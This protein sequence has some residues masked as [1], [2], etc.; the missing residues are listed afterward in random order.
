MKKFLIAAAPLA[1]L[2]ACSGGGSD[3]LQAG[4]WTMTTTMTD[5]E[6]PGMPEEMVAQMRESMGDQANTDTEC[7]TEEEAANPLQGMFS[8]N[9]MG[10]NCDF[11]ESTFEGGVINISATCEAPGGQPG[12]ATMAIEGTYTATT[13]EAEMSVA[14]EGGPMEMNMSGTMSGERTGDCEA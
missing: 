1:L 4:E 10:E 13:M 2:G 3:S 11:G 9:E 6:V 8:N 14:V 7:I 12:T 5:I